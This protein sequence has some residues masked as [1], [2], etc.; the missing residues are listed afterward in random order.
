MPDQAHDRY[1]TRVFECA[2]DGPPPMTRRDATELIGAALSEQATLVIVPAA[3]LHDD[4]F[5][6]KTGIAGEVVSRFVAFRLRLAIIGD[7]SR[8]VEESSALRDFI[9]E[10]N[11]GP[12]VWFLPDLQALEQRLAW[13]RH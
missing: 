9:Y 11:R 7:I 4:F 1:G 10:T 3:R 5:R 12:Y 8:F 2:P 6:L 13:G